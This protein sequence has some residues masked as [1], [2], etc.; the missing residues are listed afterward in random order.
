M[1]TQYNE[2]GESFSSLTV[3]GDEMWLHYWTLKCKSVSMAWKTADET[4]PRKFKKKPSADKVL[5]A[6][7]WD[8]QGVLQ[9]EY[10]LKGSTVTSTSY[11]DTLICLQKAIQ[12]KC[13]VIM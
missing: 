1:L 10:C 9:L 5:L 13:L 11:F 4:V 6:I 8:H 2:E 12:S 7:F 3:T